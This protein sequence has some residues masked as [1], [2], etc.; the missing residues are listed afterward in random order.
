MSFAQPMALLFFLMFIPVLL[1]YL[2]KQKRRRVSVSTLLFWE[3]VLQDEHKVTSFTKLRKLLSLLFQLLFMTFLILALARPIFSNERFGARRLV[4]LL[5]VSASMKVEESNGTRFEHAADLARDVVRGMSFGD[6]LTLVAVGNELEILCAATDSKR[7]LMKA[8]DYVEAID[9]EADFKS[10]FDFLHALPPDERQ[11]N[12]CI[13]TDGAFQPLE[14]TVPPKTDFS[15]LPVGGEEDN[16]GITA[17]QLRPLPTSPRD[18][19]IL[20]E[21]TNNTPKDVRAPYEIRVDDA[22]I[23]AGEIALPAGESVARTLR[24][25]SS[26]GGKIEVVLDY[27]DAFQIDN[28]AFAILPRQEQISV[29]LVSEGNFFLESAL[30]THHAIA[31]EV[32]TPDAYGPSLEA[33]V[34]IFDRWAP[35]ASIAGN[36][37]FINAWPDDLGIHAQG[38]IEKPLISDWNREHEIN[39]HLNLFNISIETAQKVTAPKTFDVLIEA[40]GDALVLFEK[41][42]ERQILLTTFDTTSSDLPLRVAFPVMLSNA[43]RYMSRES[44]GAENLSVAT[45]SVLTIAEIR[46]FTDFPE[47][48]SNPFL[49]RPGDA[50][51][52]DA[53]KRPAQ[54][55]D[56]LIPVN[57]VG[58]YTL[59]DDDLVPHPAFAANLNSPKESR[60]APSETLPQT[61]GTAVEFVDISPRLGSEVWV[62]LAFI[63]LGFSLL[64]WILFHRRLLE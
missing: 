59:V 28:K 30:A 53:T 17:F 52:P 24:Q 34:C 21:A 50:P 63:A 8:L 9:C 29:L 49:L 15:F 43:I 1:L 4:I 51:D 33:D 57:R 3:Q 32:I 48:G 10:A 64:E 55:A 42:S 23:D 38:T 61:T 62:Y 27:A 2:L 41:N 37:I 36:M 45:G 31:L 44:R 39:L 46:A 18:F 26:G 11:T 20:L 56:T 58:I 16:V 6:T 47:D 54:S 14:I 7:E 5:D 13:I 40:I 35:P 25:F 22:L 12:V 60:I 19:E